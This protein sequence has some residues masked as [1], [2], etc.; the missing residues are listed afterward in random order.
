MIGASTQVPVRIAQIL[1]WRAGVARAVVAASGLGDLELDHCFHN[2]KQGSRCTAC[3]LPRRTA[4]CSLLKLN[5][6]TTRK[7]RCQADTCKV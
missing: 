6:T 2:A 1:T 5:R 3:E 7:A 4:I